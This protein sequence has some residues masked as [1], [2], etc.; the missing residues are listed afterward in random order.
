MKK[1]LFML[2][3]SLFLPLVC[4]AQTRTVDVFAPFVSRLKAKASE[5]S[6]ALSWKNSQDLSGNKLIY[7]YTEEI[8]EHNFENAGLIARVGTEENSYTDYPVEQQNYFYAVLIQD[9]QQL[10]AVFIPFRNITSVGR[11]IKSLAPEEVLAAQIT[12]ISAVAADDSI[13]IHFS[14]SRSNRELLL[15]RNTAAIRSS[16]DLLASA[17]PV[18]LDSGSSSYRD[19]PIPGIDYY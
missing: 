7:R 10:Y 14:A 13:T 11:R 18:R 3:A 9:E 17:S 12:G 1:Y 16:D 19:Y 6:I 4:F 15:F 8:G 2:L 5:S